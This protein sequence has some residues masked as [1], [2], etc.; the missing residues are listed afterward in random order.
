METPPANTFRVTATNGRVNLLQP[1]SQQS[2]GIHPHLYHSSL[3]S[4]RATLARTHTRPS[5]PFRCRP[6]CRRHDLPIPPAACRAPWGARCPTRHVHVYVALRSIL[7]LV[8]REIAYHCRRA[9]V[10][11]NRDPNGP[12][13]VSCH[14]HLTRY[15]IC[16]S[17]VD[18]SGTRQGRHQLTQQQRQ[19]GASGIGR[20][21]LDHQPGYGR[22]AC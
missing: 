13:H 9:D 16:R 11:G 12:P 7:P 2:R 10:G 6:L 14:P 15:A 5:L 18:E 4:S 8:A 17:H 22:E 19:V 20:D 3:S 1:H 21:V